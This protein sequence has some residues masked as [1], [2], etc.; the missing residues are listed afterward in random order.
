MVTETPQAKTK[1]LDRC[2]E[3][4]IY[5]A[6]KPSK[7]VAFETKLAREILSDLGYTEFEIEAQGKIFH[8]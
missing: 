4:L 1:A 3:L 8:K 6:S 7:R 2:H 5:L